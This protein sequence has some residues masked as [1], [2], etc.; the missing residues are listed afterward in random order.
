MRV[1]CDLDLRA[2]ELQRL[3]EDRKDFHVVRAVAWGLGALG[4]IPCSPTRFPVYSWAIDGS[5]VGINAGKAVSHPNATV[6]ISTLRER[7]NPSLLL[8]MREE[9]HGKPHNPYLQTASLARPARFLLHQID[10]PPC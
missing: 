6:H 8:A 10:F 7:P 5:V 9:T 3:Y 1:A 4:S 2:S